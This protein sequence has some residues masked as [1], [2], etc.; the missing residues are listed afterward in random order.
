M[1]PALV[2]FG[3]FFVYPV[4]SVVFTSFTKWNGISAPVFTGFNNY[5]LLFNDPVFIR[6]IKNNC[7]WAL[8]AALVQIPLALVAA[9]I[10]SAKP[11]GWKTF[12]VIYFL[13]HVI[14]G[15]AIA[16][17]WA[18]IYN[19]EYGILNKILQAAGIGNLARNWLG[20]LD[21]AFPAALIY[22]LLYI[23]YYMVIMLA[24]IVSIPEIYYEAAGIDGA[25]PI[26]QAWHITL[27]LISSVS[28][29]TCMTLAIVYGFRQFEQVFILTGGGPANRTSL[30]VIY[31]YQ[32]MKNTAYGLSSAAGVVL[33]CI[34]SIV[35]LIVRK[36]FPASGTEA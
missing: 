5:R 12:R 32:Q 35:I 26:Q 11:R 14:S 3:V 30:L 21:T 9:L 2:L 19:N 4:I 27:P 25:S 23:G 31:L 20:N 6:S 16:V 24:D 28:L 22:P 7:I 33:I 8:S 17:L 13:P 18:L 15:A 34:G 29:R 10:L 1:L 36:L